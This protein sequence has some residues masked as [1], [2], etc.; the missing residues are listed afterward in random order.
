M[1]KTFEIHK[2]I[3]HSGDIIRTEFVANFDSVEQCEDWLEKTI[4]FRP[5]QEFI[6]LTVY[7]QL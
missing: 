7:K 2:L 5:S 3:T 6:L 1:K 4:E